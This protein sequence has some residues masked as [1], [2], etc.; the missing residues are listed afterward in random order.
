MK[1][2]EIVNRCQN[3]GGTKKEHR[4]KKCPTRLTQT[5]WKPWT[6]A[7]YEIAEALGKATARELRGEG[8][9][10]GKEMRAEILGENGNG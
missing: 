4:Q 10:A 5:T 2:E 8:K 1:A 9:Q 7:E 6:I 3:C